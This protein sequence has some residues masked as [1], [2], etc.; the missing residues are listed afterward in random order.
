MHRRLIRKNFCLALTLVLL[1]GFTS[2]VMAADCDCMCCGSV[3]KGITQGHE[4]NVSFKMNSG[5]A[6]PPEGPHG[7]G[8]NHCTFNPMDSPVDSPEAVLSPPSFFSKHS[9][10]PGRLIAA[11]AS[12]FLPHFNKI[13]NNSDPL[14][15]YSSAPIYL[16]TLAIRI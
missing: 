6:M 5:Q 8:C 3:T 4:Q 7:S 10:T 15:L 9:Q 14:L 1:V 2:P 11:K 12:S 16:K 13:E